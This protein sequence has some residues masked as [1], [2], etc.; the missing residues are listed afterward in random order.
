MAQSKSLFFLTALFATMVVSTA[1]E[2]QAAEVSFLAAGSSAMWET[3]A[4]AAFNLAGPG[5]HH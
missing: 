2:A 3:F 5:A 4:L 1:A